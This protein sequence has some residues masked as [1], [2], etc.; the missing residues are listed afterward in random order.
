M[1]KSKKQYFG[2]NEED[3]VIGYIKSKSGSE[4][5]RIYNNILSEPF[6]MMIQSILRRY[7]THIGNYEMEEVEAFALTHLIEHMIKYRP[8]IIEYFDEKKDKWVKLDEKGRFFSR[9]KADDLLNNLNNNDD[10]VV[11]RMFYSKAFSY[12]QTIVRNYFK[13]WGKKTYNDKKINLNYDEYVED[14]NQRSEFYYEL[15]DDNHHLLDNLINTVVNEIED[16]LDT[17]TN[18]KKNEIV[19]GEAIINVLNNWEF[20]FLE[21]SPS[22]KYNK[23]VTNKFAKNK[24]LLFL[25]E[26]TGLNTKEI[27]MAMK[28]F[29]EIYFLEKG[30][31]IDD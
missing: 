24:I 13:D 20:L 27:R 2:D 7:S 17:S 19:V 26:Q 28:P 11:Y 10:G 16:K 1:K 3:A 4:K 15:E 12:C 30:N 5:N 21:D 14:I 22:G 9:D 25:K 6:R 23:K 8:Y 18:L 31:Y 29:K